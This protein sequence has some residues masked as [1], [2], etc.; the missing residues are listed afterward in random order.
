M[1]HEHEKRKIFETLMKYRNFKSY[2]PH[3][4][5]TAIGGA[6]NGGLLDKFYDVKN[7]QLDLVKKKCALE[8]DFVKLS[9]RPD[10]PKKLGTNLDYP[11][12]YKEIARANTAR[13]LYDI[14]KV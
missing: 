8:L 3:K 12:A 2:S 13:P 5:Y 11:H 14:Q 7:S 9:P 10:I 1:M 4:L 6:G